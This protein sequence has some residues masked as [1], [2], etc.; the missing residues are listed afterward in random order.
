[1]F[2]AD[3]SYL[4]EISDGDEEFIKEMIETF[5]EE[6][7]KDLKQITEL[8][9]QKDWQSVAKTAHKLKSSIKMFGFSQLRD[10][11]FDIEQSGKNLVDTDSL[12][13]KVKDF[14]SNCETALNELKKHL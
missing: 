14:V 3:F 7:P 13:T 12:D 4:R 8:A 1:M 11:A 10:Q 6:T 2:K 9:K 5:A